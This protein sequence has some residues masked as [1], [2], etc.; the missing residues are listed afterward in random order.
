ML[1]L[2]VFNREALVEDLLVS[3]LLASIGD[4]VEAALV[5]VV[6]EVVSAAVVLVDTVVV[7]KVIQPSE[8]RLNLV[9]FYVK[10][11]TN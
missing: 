10:N 4:L 1:S 5:A 8:V 9:V 6:L 2:A 7:F 3:L 11:R